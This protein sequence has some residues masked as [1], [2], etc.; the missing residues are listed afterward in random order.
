MFSNQDKKARSNVAKLSM[1]MIKSERFSQSVAMRTAW[2]IV[3][4]A[5]SYISDSEGKLSREDAYKFA[6][7]SCVAMT[8]REEIRKSWKWAA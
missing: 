3:R 2:Q 6:Y 4:F 7:K 5:E 8:R 1:Q